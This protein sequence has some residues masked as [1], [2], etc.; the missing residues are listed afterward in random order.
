MFFLVVQI[1]G[2]VWLRDL[3]IFVQTGSLVQKQGKL[4]CVILRRLNVSDPQQETDPS[5]STQEWEYIHFHVHSPSPERR[6]GCEGNLFPSTSASPGPHLW[7]PFVPFQ[8]KRTNLRKDGSERIDHSMRVK[9]NPL[10]L[11][12]D[13]SLEGEFDLVQRIIY[14]VR[15]SFRTMVEGGG[16]IN[17]DLAG[18]FQRGLKGIQIK[19]NS[20]AS[21][22]LES[23]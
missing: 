13:S 9:F 8:G 23:C 15:H 14:E 10:A 21:R 4:V 19:C 22:C 3:A 1:V 18:F 5:T 16:S 11:L 6:G 17:H 7:C 12:L 20:G 2:C